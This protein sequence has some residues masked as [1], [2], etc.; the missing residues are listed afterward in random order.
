M[1][2]RPPEGHGSTFVPHPVARHYFA[3]SA[4]AGLAIAGILRLELGVSYPGN[5]ELT[6]PTAYVVSAVVAM[7]I[8]AWV[9]SIAYGAA[10]PAIPRNNLARRSPLSTARRLSAAARSAS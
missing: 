1:N 8:L 4:M 9:I 7:G 5:P 10:L 2:T 6:S 3:A